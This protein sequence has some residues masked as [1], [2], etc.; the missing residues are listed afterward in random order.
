[1]AILKYILLIIALIVSIAGIIKQYKRKRK[2]KPRGWILISLYGLAFF[3]SVLDQHL[4]N[5][6]SDD[7]QK[8]LEA[9]IDSVKYK[10]DSAKFF[11]E[12]KLALLGTKFDSLQQINANNLMGRGYSIFNLMCCTK[13]NEYLGILNNEQNSF[14]CYGVSII[15][16]DM[17]QL[18]KCKTEKIGSDFIIDKNCYFK[19][20]FSIPD[21]GEIQKNTI[22]IFDTY[23]ITVPV[24]EKYKFLEV[25]YNSR[26]ISVVQQMVI[27]LT[28]SGVCMQSYRVYE[29][30]KNNNASLI[31]SHNGIKNL[32]VDWDKIFFPVAR[33]YLK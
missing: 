4:D 28:S 14:P 9:K 24:D 6:K 1:M 27:E 25:K 19:S 12:T 31:K 16:A 18:R 30:Q 11:L 23:R 3:F 15:I 8:R 33:T 7:K 21:I 20:V 22:K 29:I 10:S 2:V 17:K 32:K 13:P 5:L 26:S